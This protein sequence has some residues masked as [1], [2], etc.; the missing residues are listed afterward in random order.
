M[1]AL[2]REVS[3]AKIHLVFAYLKSIKYQHQKAPEIFHRSK[4]RH[5][6]RGDVFNAPA[7]SLLLNVSGPGAEFDDESSF[8]LPLA[9][10]FSLIGHRL[11]S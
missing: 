8:G 9:K 5:F 7:H 4:R 10:L 11:S 6:A 1:H 3:R 2:A